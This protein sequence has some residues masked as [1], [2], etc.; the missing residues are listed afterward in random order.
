MIK[1]SGICKNFTQPD[2]T[3]NRA[4]KDISFE[5]ATG[6]LVV[7]GGENGSGKSLL[8][9][10]LSDLE[11]PTSGKVESSSRI[12]LVFQDADAQI[13]ADTTIEDV[14]FG[15]DK[16]D[17]RDAREKALDAL[18][19]VGLEAKADNPSHFLSGGEKRRLAIASILALGRDT[20]IFDEPYSNLDYP[21]VKSV[22]AI[23]E[24]LKEAGLTIIILTHE[25]E[26][27]LG[28]ADRFMVLHQGQLVYNGDPEKALSLDLESWGIR[29][30][31][32]SLE[33]L[34]WRA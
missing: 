29:K 13:L 6:E 5:I 4:L 34:V 16:K 12:G 26:K 30:P 15:L 24:S 2:G 28:L 31:E 3:L 23:I 18:R 33:S 14:L 8:M 11:N 10:I 21:G 1:A 27:C 19:K 20:L 25:L 9:K 22:N 32:G 17:K 7:I